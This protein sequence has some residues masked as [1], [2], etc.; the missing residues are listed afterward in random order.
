MTLAAQAFTSIF[1]LVIAAFSVLHRSD[2][3]RLG[4]RLADA[5]ALP[6]AT[7]ASLLDA[8]PAESEQVATFG[9]LSLLIVL[10]SATSFSRALT[11]MYAR[12]WSV[13]PPGWT[14]GWRWI[15][16][17][18]AIAACTVLLKAVQQAAEG[19]R[20]AVTAALLLTFVVGSALWTWLPWVLLA[21]GVR[22][23]L[24]AP[25]GLIM[26]AATVATFFAS[27]IYMP[28]ALRYASGRYG[29]LGVAFTYIGWLFAVSFVLVMAT[30]V[31][32]V[33]TREPGVISRWL[34]RGDDAH[35]AASTSPTAPFIPRE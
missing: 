23:Q 15:A 13:R 17:V 4:D 27:R 11:R 12:A 10:L 14:A 33:L 26:G 20:A 2:A 5:L 6:A 22:W 31:G 21:G 3:E 34:T 24:L 32:T 29:D 25:A 19:D 9:L 35:P 16:A 18:V 30:V 1:P 8:L 7:R 28:R